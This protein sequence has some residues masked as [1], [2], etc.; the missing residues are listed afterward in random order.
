MNRNAGPEA[1]GSSLFT[2][3]LGLGLIIMVVFY[4][5]TLQK[6]LTRVSP[7]NRLMDPGLVWLNLIPIFNIIWA[8]FIAIR[9]PG[10]LKNEFRSRGLDDGSDYG[11]GIAL[12]NCILGVISTFVACAGFSYFFSQAVAHMDH[13]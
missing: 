11:K 10:S 7:R 1:W 8:F 13:G 2:C 12:A 3:G 6:A 4:L 9:V 5:L